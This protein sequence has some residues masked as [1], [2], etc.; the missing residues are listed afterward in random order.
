MQ[1]TTIKIC[2][3]NWTG[4]KEN[5]VYLYA[6]LIEHNEGI[7]HGRLIAPAIGSRK[8]QEGA[9]KLQM[10]VRAGEGG[11]VFIASSEIRWIHR[12]EFRALSRC[13]GPTWVIVGRPPAA[14]FHVSF[15]PFKFHKLNV[16]SFQ[17]FHIE[18]NRNRN[19]VLF[20]QNILEE[21]E[22]GK[23]N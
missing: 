20:D 1:S 17:P 21:R 4:I 2:E 10:R 23:V 11:G 5:N 15:Q 16:S 6:H 14:Q 13:P 12:R 22:I 9:R 8:E 7:I 18:F 3:Q 19:H